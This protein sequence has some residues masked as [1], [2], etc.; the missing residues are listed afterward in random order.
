MS[1]PYL[2]GRVVVTVSY[3]RETVTDMLRDGRA[4]FEAHYWEV[5]RFNGGRPFSLDESY[6]LGAEAAGLTRIF[7]ARMVGELIGYSAHAVTRHALCDML[8]SAQLSFAVAPIYR[9]SGVGLELLNYADTALR[10]EG[11]EL[12]FQCASLAPM[13]RM[14]ERAGYELIDQVYLRRSLGSCL[15]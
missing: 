5:A 13:A 2:S 4:L 15:N 1:S 8:Q 9:R 14:L 3:Q 7:T 6:F 12:L 11:V 10:V